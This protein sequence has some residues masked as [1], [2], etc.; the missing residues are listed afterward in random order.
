MIEKSLNK[1][2]M[3]RFLF[4]SEVIGQGTYGLVVKYNEDTLLKIYYK[5]II[6]TYISKN[7]EKLDEEINNGIKIEETMIELGQ[8]STT[9]LENMKSKKIRTSSANTH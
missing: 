7:I 8:Q 9:T 3:K 2:D 6:N 5:N 1:D 4:E